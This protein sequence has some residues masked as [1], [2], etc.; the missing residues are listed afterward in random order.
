LALALRYLP[1]V[2]ALAFAL[3]L[4]VHNVFVMPRWAPGLMRPPGPRADAGV[5]TY[6]VVVAGLVLLF[7]DRLA[8]A[9]AG[10]AILGCGDG[11]AAVFGRALGGRAFL[12]CK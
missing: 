4:V 10:W 3:V 5:V 6:P 11:A 12:N 9:A 7:H 2:A 8:L 1:P